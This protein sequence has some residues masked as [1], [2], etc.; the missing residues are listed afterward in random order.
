LAQ[1]LVPEDEQP[2]AVPENWV[3][4]R[5]GSVATIIGGGTPS[6]NVT[7][8]YE[9]GDISWITP[10]DLSNY[11]SMYI[12]YGKKNIT[13]L[14]LEKS[15]A[16]LMPKNSVLLST[17]APIGYVVIAQK[18]LCTN[19]G[20]KSFL[21]SPFFTPEYLYYYLK[22]SKEKLESYAS[23]TTFLELSG[24]KTALVEFPLP[25]LPEQKRIV[26]RIESL[27]KKL[28]RAKDLTQNVL[29]SFETR[30]AAI[31]HKAFAGELTAKWREENEVGMESWE[32][33][34]LGQNI[35]LL[36][37]GI[38][39]TPEYNDN[40]NFYF[41][42]GN[43]LS[44]VSIEIKP[45]TKRIDKTE[46]IKHK[47]EM[48][49]STVLVSING[50]LG[51][52]A[53]YNGE[54][55]ILGKSA[56]YF[57]VLDCLEKRFIRYFLETKTYLDYANLIATGSTIKNLS[58]KAMRNLPLKLPSIPEQRE[59]IR[60]LDSLFYKEQ[61]AYDLGDIIDEIDLM[62]KAILARAFR[63]E[64]G[65]NNPNEESAEG[66]FKEIS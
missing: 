32:E 37:D 11:K 59:I 17:R 1:A 56:C 39:G 25:S 43:N 19:Q 14:G 9:G 7:E 49:N 57:N 33:T 3:W 50:T 13:V 58:L 44:G 38:H 45:D 54:P 66:L 28:D 21:P 64:L 53:F 63:G 29:D 16:R 23:G 48:N 22:Y 6:S 60:I 15:S 36:G 26:K 35:S 55:V 62:K 2:Y 41:I 40:G 34:T 61:C 4:V 27:F 30:K 51:K 18:E 20:F 8:Y 12:S 65:T 24:R 52:T 42:N 31:L 46:F 10:A 47:K 5:L